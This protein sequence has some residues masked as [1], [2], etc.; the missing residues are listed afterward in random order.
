[1]GTGEKKITAISNSN[2]F[3]LPSY[4]EGLPISVLEAMSYGMPVISTRVGDIEDAVIEG[5]N[6]FLINPGDVESLAER[7]VWMK[8]KQR[9][10]R[11]SNG[12]RSIAET[13][14]D[15]MRFY[16]RLSEVWKEAAK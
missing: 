15:I 14:F 13:R 4:N 7:I 8:D 12:A 11:L 6:G 16:E 2:V 1:M 5:E 3:I 9:W 10:D